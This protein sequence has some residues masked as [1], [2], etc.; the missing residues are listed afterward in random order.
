MNNYIKYIVI[1]ILVVLALS[2][3][4]QAGDWLEIHGASKHRQYGYW[5]EV[6]TPEYRADGVGL[7]PARVA[8]TEYIK[9]PY[10]ETNLGVGLMHGLDEHIEVGFG[11]YENS[12]NR[13]SFYTGLD[14][15]TS[16]RRPI[17]AGVS[18]GIVS[19]YAGYQAPVI[20]LPNITMRVCDSA[21]IKVGYLPGDTGLVTFTMGVRF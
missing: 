14:Y 3:V 5:E 4:C 21:R 11:Y 13:N 19:G 8:H 9:R 2:Q 20:I 15:H 1:P 16:D 18:A 17:R 10:N 7:Q 12:Y 6:T